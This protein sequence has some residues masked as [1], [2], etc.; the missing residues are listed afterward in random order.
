[1][2]SSFCFIR[3]IGKYTDNKAIKK[4]VKIVELRASKSYIRDTN[5]FTTDI[6]FDCLLT[7]WGRVTHICVRYLTTISSDNGLSPG[8]RQAITC[9]NAEVS[10]IGSLWTNF[11]E[12]WIEIPTFSYKKIRFKL[13]S[14]KWR[15]FCVCLNVLRVMLWL[16]C[17]LS[18]MVVPWERGIRSF[19]ITINVSYNELIC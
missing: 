11:S 19:L 18:D 7:H 15:P 8:R 3:E 6:L 2:I 17:R 5:Q 9:T 12:V 1:M 10:L 13:S 4:S 16:W 14:A